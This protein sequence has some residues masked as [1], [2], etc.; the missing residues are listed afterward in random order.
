MTN[1][2]T[3]DRTIRV[4]AGLIPFALA[5]GAVYFALLREHDINFY[6]TTKPP[7][8][9]GAAALI[10][11]GFLEFLLDRR[12]WLRGDRS[13][14]VAGRLRLGGSHLAAL[15]G[16]RDPYP[17]A[18]HHLTARL[19]HHRKDD[20]DFAGPACCVSPWLSRPGRSC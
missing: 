2:G 4:L 5:C 15:L 11:L 9:W 10:G 16:R 3:L 1:E 20:D 8:F 13:L 17:H 12:R 18:R 19:H 7:A 14:A 6:L